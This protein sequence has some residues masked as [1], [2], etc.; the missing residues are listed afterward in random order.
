M[1]FLVRAADRISSRSIAE[2]AACFVK[3]ISAVI[4][5]IGSGGQ[6]FDFFYQ[7]EYFDPSSA[8][9]CDFENTSNTLPPPQLL[10]SGSS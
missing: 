3:P 7:S 1:N 9:P 4:R 6:L 5:W 10:E 8:V 2:Q